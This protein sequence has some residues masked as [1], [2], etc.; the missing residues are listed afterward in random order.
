MGDSPEMDQI[1]IQEEVGVVHPHYSSHINLCMCGS[2]FY[3]TAYNNI[4]LINL[5]RSPVATIVVYD[6]KSQECH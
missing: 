4:N 1:P 5:N 2:Q 6:F 3:T